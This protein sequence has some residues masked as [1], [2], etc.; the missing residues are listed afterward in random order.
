MGMTM[1]KKQTELNIPV[2]IGEAPD[3]GYYAHRPTEPSFLLRR[4][5]KDEIEELALKVITSY[6]TK[7]GVDDI[8]E[9]DVTEQWPLEIV[10][11]RRGEPEVVFDPHEPLSFVAYGAGFNLTKLTA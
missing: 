7:F 10:D 2:L 6:V 11:A 3:G 9:F 4:N 1:N 8:V 5:T